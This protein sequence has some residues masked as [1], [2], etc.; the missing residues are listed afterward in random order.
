MLR[1]LIVLAVLV[2]VVQGKVWSWGTMTDDSRKLYEGA[3]TRYRKD[4]KPNQKYDFTISAGDVRESL[5]QR[6]SF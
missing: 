5:L 6:K 2:A 3:W 1:S 4:P